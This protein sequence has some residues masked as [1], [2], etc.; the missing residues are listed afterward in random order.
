MNSDQAPLPETRSNAL[1]WP[2]MN[3]RADGGE[4][5]DGRITQLLH[6]WGQ[7]EDA[8]RDE[9]LPLVYAELKAIARRQARS[10]PSGA[11]LT[12]TAVVHELYLR[13][14]GQERARWRNR[15]QF[16]AVASRLMRRVLVDHARER[17]A[18]KRGGRALRVELAED[19]AFEM[20]M[21][22]DLLA[23]DRAL[24]RLGEVDPRLASAVELRC[25]LGLTIEE[26]GEVLQ[27]STPTVKRDMRAARAFLLRELSA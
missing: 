25:F 2:S 23:L 6:S 4:A 9:L 3:E 21:D 19:V 17:L 14:A 24:E 11:T 10:E 5:A 12:P 1:C 15:E 8:A 7:G 13:L 18:E 22:V 26:T 16:F 27:V 20:P